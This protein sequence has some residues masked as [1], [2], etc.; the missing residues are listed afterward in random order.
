MY[1]QLDDDRGRANVH[2]A[3]ATAD[4]YAHDYAAGRAHGLEAL[5]RNRALGDTFGTGWSLHMV[6]FAELGLQMLDE[7]EQHF[8][9]ALEVFRDTDDRSALVMLFADLSSLARFQGQQ[10]RSWRLIGASDRLRAETGADLVLNSSPFDWSLPARPDDD[11]DALAVW[12]EGH[13]MSLER[14]IAYALKE[15]PQED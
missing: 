5:A 2:W 15:L 8:D 1:D 7:A 10:K 11:P 13:D 9:A 14:A 12:Q 4:S 3:L 6:G